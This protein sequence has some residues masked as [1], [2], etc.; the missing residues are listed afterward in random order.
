MTDSISFIIPGPP[1]AA[2]RPRGR[3]KVFYT[4]PKYREGLKHARGYAERAMSGLE[5]HRGPVT[6]IV[7]F[8]HQVGP[9]SKRTAASRPD[10]DNN[11]K[12][13]MDSMNGVV[14][15]DDAQ[16]V[17]V[18]ATKCVVCGVPPRTEVTVAFL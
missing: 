14:F 6:L 7:H 5:P 17:K 11:L 1:V 15:A 8:A 9:K 10:I 16:I 4:P 3:G 18:V 13:C 2:Q 12:W